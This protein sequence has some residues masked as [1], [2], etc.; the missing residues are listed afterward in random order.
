MQF[1]SRVAFHG[2]TLTLH[3]EAARRAT[4]RT[5]QTVAWCGG[6][7][8]LMLLALRP[9]AGLHV[10]WDVV[11]PVAPALMAIVPGVWRNICPLGTTSQLARHTGRS[12]SRQLS[13]PWQIAFQTTGLGLLLAVVALRH[14]S[15][16]VDA[17]ATFMALTLA[18]LMAFTAG[19][20]FSGKSGWCS[21]LC[22]VHPVEKLYGQAPA[23]T[24][25]N[26]HCPTCVRCTAICPDSTKAMSPML[27]KHHPWRTPAA[28]LLVGG[29]PGYIWGWFHVPDSATGSAGVHL[30][31]AF[32]RPFGA[33]AVSL[34]VFV[35]LSKLLPRARHASLARTFAAAAISIYYW[36]RLPALV[37]IGVFP[38]EGMLVDLHQVVA[39]GT[40]LAV[41]LS[42]T[43]F[44]A[45]WLV[46][47]KPSRAWQVRP[48]FA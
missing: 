34:A 32:G 3:G 37:G 2:L 8:L 9:Q 11:L 6:A 27:G 46:V 36:Y 33:M 15:L 16:N 13:E 20:L 40:M 21:G 12:L 28:W 5:A 29:F 38:G 48:A 18:A 14:V 23:V 44:W 26:A 7:A 39:T 10:M 43:A 1:Q 31:T 41:Q 35:A 22:P 17:F 25:K 45:W 47:R 24:V 4:C 30:V 19:V 42:V